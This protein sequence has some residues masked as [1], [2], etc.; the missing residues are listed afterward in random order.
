MFAPEPWLWLEQ[1]LP[2]K[3]LAEKY[4]SSA[5][6][7]LITQLVDK[8]KQTPLIERRLVD[9]RFAPRPSLVP[10]FGWFRFHP[11]LPSACTAI[12][13]SSVKMPSTPHSLSFVTSPGVFTVHTYTRRLIRCA[14]CTCSL[15]VLAMFGCNAW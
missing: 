9:I 8:I 2:E 12:C 7:S 1:K 13:G 4:G 3:L 14:R 10:V 11:P 15:L 6:H 5:Y